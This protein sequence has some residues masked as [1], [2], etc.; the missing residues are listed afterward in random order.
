MVGGIVSV[1]P[2]VVDVP[3]TPPEK[4]P[5]ALLTSPG[6]PMPVGLTIGMFQLMSSW[7]KND[8]SSECSFLAMRCVAL[9]WSQ[10][11]TPLEI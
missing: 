10:T 3:L 11:W 9:A 2:S 8:V 6:D 1:H 7:V 4:I 5:R